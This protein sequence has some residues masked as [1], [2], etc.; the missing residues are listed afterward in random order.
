M[1][2]CSCSILASSCELFLPFL[3]FFGGR[4]CFFILHPFI[5]YLLSIDTNHLQRDSEDSSLI[6]GDPSN[7][8]LTGEPSRVTD[9]GIFHLHREPSMIAYNLMSHSQRVSSVLCWRCML[10]V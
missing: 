3:S 9:L 10:R 1:F 5:S 2:C 6:P 4:G 7:M 8:D